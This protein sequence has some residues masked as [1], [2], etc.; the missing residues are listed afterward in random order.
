MTVTKSSKVAR[1]ASDTARQ[2]NKKHRPTSRA[3]LIVALLV[4]FQIIAFAD[5]A[6]LGLVGPYAMADLGLNATQFG[7]IGS[8]FFFL[9]AIVSVVTGILASKISVHWILFTLGVVWAV[10]Q[11]PML[12]GGGA[13]VLLATRIILGGA[14]G[15]ATAMSLTSAHT[16]F[17]P[18]RRALPSN[19]VAIG[20]TMGPVFAA[21]F[22]A[23]VIGMW[24]WRWAFG[25]LGIIGLVWI[26][27][28]L[29][30]GGDGP[31][32]QGSGD[33][34]ATDATDATD[35]N[36]AE[37]S[38]VVE[39]A[40]AEE[41]T[42]TDKVDDQKPVNIWRALFSVAFFAALFGAIS[43]FWVQGFLT[44]WLP[45]YLGTVLGF[46]LAEVGVYTTFPWVLGALVLLIMGALGQRWMS[47]GANAHVAIAVPFGLSTAIAGLAF[48]LIPSS[49]GVLG[50]ILLSIAGGCSLVFPMT[51][52]AIGY[53]VGPKQRPIMM[54][55]LG[56]FGAFGAIVSPVLVGWLMTAAGYV[57]PENGT[58]PS[59][60]MVAAMTSG[61]N[62]AF[63]IT[64]VLLVTA[65][66]AAAIFLRP[67]RLGRKLQSQYVT[68][69]S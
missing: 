56:G 35:A 13:A 4:I 54:A 50:V 1:H 68:K 9:Y 23:W 66:A 29:V 28:W 36:S 60:E 42:E 45:Q 24:G 5:K 10:V 39:E 15:P 46:S 51:A 20:S 2:Q 22:I 59:G 63:I 62:T 17:H 14:E 49:S 7:F 47:R 19:L 33:K 11:F 38:A 31:Y 16:W 65:G 69:A 30:L 44:T 61:V 58:A 41:E 57:A 40:A 37:G 32:R 18:S 26:V 6:V 67:E 53:A 12:L 55:T 21:P 8:A 52:S 64:G 27:A 43:N 3:W 48:L 34:S 25:A